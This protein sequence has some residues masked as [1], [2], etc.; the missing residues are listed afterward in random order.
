MDLKIFSYNSTGFN[1]EKG[2]FIDFLIKSMNINIFILQE[3]MHLR[4]NVYKIQNAFPNF[5]SFIIPASK[6]NNCVSSGRPSGGLAIF[7]EKAL[8]FNVKMI[9][10]PD[11]LR[12]QAIELC[13]NYLLINS[14]FPT[15]PQVANFDDFQLLKCIEDVKWFF[16][17]FPNHNCIFA[18][19]LNLDLSRNTRFVNIMREFFLNSNLIS[20]WSS[21]NVDFTFS[22]HQTRNGRNILSTSC[23]D[24]FVVQPNIF[25]D[26]SHAQVIHLGDNLSNHDPI[27]L[28][29]KLD[30]VPIVSS[31]ENS[32]SNVHIPKPMWRKASDIHINSYRSDLKSKLSRLVLSDGIL[33]N[34]PSCSDSNHYKDVD[35][36][37]NCIVSS[38]DSA[39]HANIPLSKPN[40]SNSVKPGWSVLVKPFQD[41]AKFW[42]A[43]WISLG[44]PLNCQIYNVMKHTRNQYHYAVRRVKNNASKIEQDNMLVSFLDGKAPDLIKKL[45]SH[46]T[47]SK[48]KAP[49][50]MDGK[51]GSENIADHFASKY[52]DLY[53]MNESLADTNAL[54]NSLNFSYNDMSD[55]E[56]VSPEIVYQAITCINANKS[57]NVFD[58]KSNAFLN[59]A[60]LLTNHLTLLLQTFLI[61]GYVPTELITCSL[62]PIVKDKLGDKHLSENYRAIGISSLILK[63]LDWVILILFEDKLKPSDL[64]FGFQKKNSTTMCSWVVNESINYFNNRDTPVFSCFLDL[65]KAFDLV[66]FSKLFTKL[67]DK[68]S[69]VFI[70]LLAYIYVYQ[71]CCVEWCGIKSK[72]F[73]VS[74][75]VRQGAVLSPILFSLY[76]DDLFS[77]LA[78]SGFGCYINNVFYGILGYADDLV[79]LSPNRYGLQCMLN[80]AKS[81][82]EKL[83][84]KISVNHVIP[85]KSK[86]KC[87]S[88]GIKQ[89]L[90]PISLDGINLPWSDT[91]EHLGHVLCKDGSLKLDVDL[92]R[93]SFIGKYHELRQELKNPYPIVFM[94]L[95]LIYN[96]H[97]YGSN[98]WNLFA[99]NDVYTAWNNVFRYVFDLPRCTHRYLLEP[100]TECKHLFTL[101][102]N[103]FLK[104]YRTLFLSGKNIIS[105]LRRLQEKDCRS[106]FGSNIKNICR[107]ND[108]T[109]I[110]ACLKD[111]V[112]YFPINVSDCWRV[113]LL[114]ELMSIRDNTHQ[115]EGFSTAEINL[116]IDNLACS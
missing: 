15:D 3:H 35:A 76:I 29:I 48:P 78:R 39:V 51:V 66:T 9:K 101:L 34:D 91:Y 111:S 28:S 50:H 25:G 65:S 98:L 71:S 93:R 86:T 10:H 30:S 84:L 62:K 40:A 2:R 27:F 31:T 55:V 69:S 81:F 77:E 57:D 74:N 88:F 99:I 115:L 6:S 5:E 109:D 43:I 112:K 53:N 33:C 100:V 82:L 12:V 52:F 23:I 102:T 49:S 85:K 116:F 58:F 105:N 72:S 106:N 103:R 18:G 26:I 61:H 97:F 4:Q 113:D 110:H 90:L 44:K 56:K 19:D 64:Q 7:W 104:F 67:R 24:H 87:V 41:D 92:K 21:F 79:L 13:G 54:L 16:N 89:D 59:A 1:V 114:K 73:K 32:N 37:C 96:S 83:G 42:H 17:S 45:K 47:N 60:D 68:I 75:G 70:R 20:V 14:Y 80:L 46:R 94:N 63:V 108:T 38:I 8:N 36:F 22:N 107:L 11:S 95:I